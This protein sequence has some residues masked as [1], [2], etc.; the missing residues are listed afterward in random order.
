MAEKDKLTDYV[1]QAIGSLANDGKKWLDLP[2]EKREWN[3]ELHSAMLAKLADSFFVKKGTSLGKG[4][5]GVE[6]KTTE[7][8]FDIDAFRSAMYS[9]PA[10]NEQSNFKKRLVGMLMVPEKSAKVGSWK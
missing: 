3:T 6:K 7:P 5:D 8:Y 2:L 9:E 10:I 1:Q 4:K